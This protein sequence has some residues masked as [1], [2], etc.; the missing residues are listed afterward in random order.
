MGIGE[1]LEVAFA[2]GV[3]LVLVGFA[4][5]GH[6]YASDAAEDEKRLDAP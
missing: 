2:V 1:F 6:D 3:V 5:A 4:A